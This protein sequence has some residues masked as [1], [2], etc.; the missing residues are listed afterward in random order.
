MFSGLDVLINSA[1]IFT[2]GM[3][4]LIVLKILFVSLFD[5][6]FGSVKSPL[7]LYHLN[8]IHLSATDVN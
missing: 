6:I 3:Q 7:H 4:L 8:I 1:G 2:F 5:S